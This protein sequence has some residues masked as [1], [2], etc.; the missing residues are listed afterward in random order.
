MSYKV[1]N[2]GFLEDKLYLKLHL[3]LYKQFIKN[4]PS[5]LHTQ[6]QTLN[7]TRAPLR[8]QLP[9]RHTH[10]CTFNTLVK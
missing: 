3:L 2:E 5:D 10:V 7:S 1:N 8:M 6:L 4:K 9:I